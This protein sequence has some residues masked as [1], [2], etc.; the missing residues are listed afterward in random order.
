MAIKRFVIGMD[1]GA[2]KTAGILSDL[3]G[4]VLAEETSGPSNLQVVGFEKVGEVIVGLVEELSEHAGGAK[5]A[6]SCLWSPVWLV[7]EGKGIKTR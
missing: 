6:T 5:Q 3:N 1:G 2:T 4:N 7:P